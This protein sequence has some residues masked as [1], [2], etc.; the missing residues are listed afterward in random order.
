MTGRSARSIR[1]AAGGLAAVALALPLLA[2]CSAVP[3]IPLGELAANQDRYTGELVRTSGIVRPFR[4]ASGTYYV[5]EDAA[6]NRVELLPARSV[7]DYAGRS[8]TVVGTFAASDA[9][10][11]A[12]TIRSIDVAPPA[13]PPGG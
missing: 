3:S 1:G 8:I 10:G 7:A 4:D 2:A 5:L 11:R 13:S 6:A 12:L 9:T